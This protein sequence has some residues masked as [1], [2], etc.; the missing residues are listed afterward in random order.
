KIDMSLVRNVHRDPVRQRLI[1]AVVEASTSLK[2]LTVAEGVE[3][4]EERDTVVE[5]G[6]D[7]LQGYLLAKPA[8]GFPNVRW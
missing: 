4:A 2:M 8:A 1:R 3:T 6:A 5:L 7:L